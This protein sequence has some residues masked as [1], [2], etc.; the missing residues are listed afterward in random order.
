MELGDLLAVLLKP[1]QDGALSKSRVSISV[2]SMLIGEHSATAIAL[3]VHELATNSMKFGALSWATGNLDI[4]GH[5]LGG[6]VEINWRETGGPPVVSAPQPTGFG[7]RLVAA[8]VEDQLGGTI[9]V[10][11]AREG[12]TVKLKIN[13]VRLGA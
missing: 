12:V 7:S 5:D 6:E 10:D 4:S 3:V 2:P 9:A 11:W 13:K 8:S 1:Y